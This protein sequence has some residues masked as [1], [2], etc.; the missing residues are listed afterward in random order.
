MPTPGSIRPRQ[1]RIRRYAGAIPLPTIWVELGGTRLID[2]ADHEFW[3]LPNTYPFIRLDFRQSYDAD[4]QG[5]F[6]YQNTAITPAQFAANVANMVAAY[7]N[8]YGP[9]FRSVG[10]PLRYGLLLAG[11]D[12]SDSPLKLTLNPHDINDRRRQRPWN[13]LGEKIKGR[14]RGRMRRNRTMQGITFKLGSATFDDPATIARAIFQH[15]GR[16]NVRSWSTAAF[17]LAQ[18]ELAGLNAVPELLLTTFEANSR[19]YKYGYT[20]LNNVEPSFIS[21]YSA[22]FERLI[23][24][25]PTQPQHQNY[26]L[27]GDV[28]FGEWMAKRQTTREGAPIQQHDP[29]YYVN[30][31]AE[32]DLYRRMIAACDASYFKSLSYSVY[33][34]GKAAFGPQIK[35][36]EW[37]FQSDGAVYPTESRPGLDQYAERG[38]FGQDF[39]IPNNYMGGA[40]QDEQRPFGD[41]D[42]RW[43]RV[44]NWTGRLQTGGAGITERIYRWN[45]ETYGATNWGAARSNSA[46]LFPSL[47]VS[48]LVEQNLY[49]QYKSLSLDCAL[50][51][52]LDGARNFWMWEPRFNYTT[53]PTEPP[54]P[55]DIRDAAY[56]HARLLNGRVIALS[57]RRGQVSRAGQPSFSYLGVN[58]P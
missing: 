57:R 27:D 26:L 43:N 49:E 56:D 2:F 6:S 5:Y 37:A 11:L 3:K 39:Q 15:E 51:A 21:A 46:P 1:G 45:L 22:W 52:V 24:D 38:V 44:D 40:S 8:A 14:S 17:A 18:V 58:R 32:N 12:S 29:R 19:N 42:P 28:T 47:T 31:P 7:Q 9:A 48:Y 54:D 34:P 41:P 25:Y 30:H 4:G 50:R 20:V 13:L 55:Q 53:T 33:E 35:S 36:A 16:E 23:R 10:K